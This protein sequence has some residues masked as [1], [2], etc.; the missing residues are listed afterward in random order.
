MDKVITSGLLII[1]SIV[2]A[3]ALINA[4]IPAMSESSAAMS[5]ANSAASERIRT[6]IEVIHVAANP[7]ASQITIWVKN[8]GSSTILPIEAGD[9]FLDTPNT[10]K[11]LSHGSASGSEYWTYVIENGSQWTQGVTV[12]MT[13]HLSGGSVTSGG[14]SVTVSLYNAVSASRDFSV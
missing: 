3:V 11:H 4:V 6:D 9:L 7:G 13:A 5:A 2:A 1:A 10:V 8:V 14:Y 12:R